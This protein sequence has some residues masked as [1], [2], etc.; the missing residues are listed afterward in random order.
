MPILQ[1]TLKARQMSKIKPN[2]IKLLLL[3]V[4]FLASCSSTKKSG[5]SSQ[6]NYYLNPKKP[7][8]TIGRVALI[9]L[10][11]LSPRP[12]VSADMTQALFEAIQKRNVFGLSIVYHTNPACKGILIEGNEN[13]SLEQLALLHKNLKADAAL[14]GEVTQYY[15]YPR[16]A[17]GLRLKLIDL[18]DGTLIWAVEQFWDST[19]KQ[20]ENRAEDFFKTQIRSGF[21][22]IEYR[23][24][25]VSPR[26]FLKFV[27]WEVGQTLH[28]NDK[29]A[30]FDMVLK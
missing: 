10:K 12:E 29:K 11:N 6:S 26:M 25:L 19:D 7:I 20:V 21:D 13:Y 5:P 18:R 17:I 28:N 30:I 23:M 24:A 8:S 22:P 2:S 9:E 14:I 3:L 27:A 15:P 4:L 1:N 16:L